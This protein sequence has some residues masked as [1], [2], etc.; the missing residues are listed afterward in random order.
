MQYEFKIRDLKESDISTVLSIYNDHVINGFAAYSEKELSIDFINRLKKD[1]LSFIIL[2]IEEKIT[3]FAFLRNY[4]PYDNFKHTGQLSYIIKPEYTN[5]SFGTM[6]FNKLVDAAK[7]NGID[8]LIVHLSSLNQQSLNFH[9]KHGF[10]E[11]GKFKNIA[12]KFGQEFD[13]IW[14]QKNI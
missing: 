7:D 11:C 9:K 3:G 4:L 8:I 6:L 10:I 12:K 13:I 5:K 14:M 2:E 1:S